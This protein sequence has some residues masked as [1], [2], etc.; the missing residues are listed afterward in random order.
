MKKILIVDDDDELRKNLSGVLTEAGY[1]TDEAPTGVAAI[2]KA[3]VDSFDIILLDLIM[4]KMDG[5]EALTEL[6]KVSPNSKKIIIT[7][8]ATI[9]NA[10]DALKKGASHYISKPFKVEEVLTVI[11]R[12][13]EEAKF[14][15]G[16]RKLAMDNTL[17]ALANPIRRK[18]IKLLCERAKMR[19]MEITRQLEIEDHTKV[20]FHLKLLREVGLIQQDDERSYMLTKE[21]KKIT[22][23][24]KMLEN[25]LETSDA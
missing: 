12:V 15:E 23:C 8:F 14:E 21:G 13:L 17:N 7:A 2:K 18:I 9:D 19:L 24:L 22:D 16:V 20:V 11:K 3:S 5:I 25:Y 1:Q 4:P 10:I 6:R